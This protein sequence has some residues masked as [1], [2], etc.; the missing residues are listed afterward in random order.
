MYQTQTMDKVQ[1]SRSGKNKSWS[2]KGKASLKKRTT[3]AA[4]VRSAEE[5]MSSSNSPKAL[6]S[7]TGS[8]GS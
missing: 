6:D 8:G 1:H 2:Q 7:Y 5:T 3:E 4:L